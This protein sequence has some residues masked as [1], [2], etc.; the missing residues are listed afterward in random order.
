MYLCRSRDQDEDRE[1]WHKVE[2]ERQI[3]WKPDSNT[4]I[5]NPKYTNSGRKRA[6]IQKTKNKADSKPHR[7]LNKK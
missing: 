4:Q 2:F 3:I 7:D 6:N 1:S 5:S